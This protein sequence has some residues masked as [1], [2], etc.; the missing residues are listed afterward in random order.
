VQSF[1]SGS[2]LWR[3]EVVLRGPETRHQPL[4]IERLRT[5]AAG[6]PDRHSDIEE[7]HSYDMDPPEGSIGAAVWVYAEGVGEAADTGMS[8][9][10]EAASYVA[11][12]E[13]PLWDLR[14]IPRDAI[15]LAT[16]R[17]TPLVSQD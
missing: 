14:V 7:A 1:G 16:P 3:V 4:L 9:V 11:E 15:T 12:G 6:T 2:R 13:L 10:R 5:Q 17:G 8:I